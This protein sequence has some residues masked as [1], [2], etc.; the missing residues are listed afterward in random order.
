MRKLYT[1]RKLF[2]F[3]NKI[4]SHQVETVAMALFYL[5]YTLNLRSALHFRYLMVIEASL[6]IPSPKLP[7]LYVYRTHAR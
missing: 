6:G 7:F 3:L 2:Y 1:E 5:K 4:R